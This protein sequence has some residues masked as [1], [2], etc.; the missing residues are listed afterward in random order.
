MANPVNA[1][2]H[3]AVRSPAGLRPFLVLPELGLEIASSFHSKFH[4][5]IAALTCLR[6]FAMFPI[7]FRGE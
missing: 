6:D 4:R 5:S 3:G 1:R 7:V 2:E